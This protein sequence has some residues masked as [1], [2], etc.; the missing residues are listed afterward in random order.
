MPAVPRRT[1]LGALL[2]A[3]AACGDTGPHGRIKL[4]TGPTGGPYAVFGRR[5]ADE[6]HR[7]HGDLTVQVLTT[8][9]SVANLR[10]LRDGQA[11]LALALADS[12][13]DAAA[14]TATFRQGRVPVTALARLYL[15]YLHLV[16]PADSVIHAPARLAGHTVSIGAAESGTSVTAERVLAAAGVRDQVRTVRLGLEESAGALRDGE[17][18]AFFWSGGSPTRAIADLARRTAV[19]LVPLGDLAA[20]LR[21]RYGPVYE[22]V[23]LP[24]GAYGQPGPTP[25]VGTPSYL[26]CRAGLGRDTAH[27]V[28]G[29]LFTRRDRLPVPDAPGSRLD[30]RYA[31]GTGTVPLHPGAAAYYRSVYG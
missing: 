30:E 11:D 3:T 1:L 23:A 28:T 20:G 8:A 7:A 22:S 5:L 14:G 26:V 27:A 15:N 9:A 25:T 6:I 17:I 12:A 10:M 13:A 29:V 31:I 19:R 16:V 24:A 2:A 4:A 18:A 21:H